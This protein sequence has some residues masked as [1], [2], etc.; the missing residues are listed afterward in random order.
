MAISP[1]GAFFIF[2]SI[3]LGAALSKILRLILTLEERICFSI[4]VGHATSATIL[5]LISY[6]HGGLDFLTIGTGIVVI[7]VAIV[8]MLMR[9]RPSIK[10]VVTFEAERLFTI[11]FGLIAFTSLNLQCVLREKSGSLY[12]SSYVTGDYCFHISVI[13]SFVYRNNFPP[14]Y[15]VMLDASMAYPPLVD[16]LSSILMETG[17]DLRSSIIIPNVLFQVSLLCWIASLAIRITGRKNVGLL[18]ALL[19]F[20]SSNL[21]VLYAFTDIAKYGFVNWMLNLPTDYS[22]SGISP[23]PGIR[24]GNPVVVMLMPQRASSLGMGISI[25]AYALIFHAIRSGESFREIFLSGFLTGL[26]PSIHPHSF[27]TV[28]IIF[29][30]ESVLFKKNLKF[31][32]FFLTPMVILAFPQLLYIRTQV[33]AGF[34]GSSIGWLEENTVKIMS[35]NW[36]TPVGVLISALRSISILAFFWFM[37]IGLILIPFA[38]GFFK[39]S[40]FVRSFSLPYL[41]VFLL[42]NFVRFQPW[43]WDNY[44]IFLHCY[45]LILTITSFGIL[46]FLKIL[47]E[48]LRKASNT[49]MQRLKVMLG[50]T[51]LAI[52]LFF[53]TASGF[54]SHA[55]VFQEDLL[56]WPKADVEFAEWVRDNTPP[57]SIFLT[58]THFLNPIP[59]LAGRQIVLG[60][61]GWLWSHGIRW[62]RIQKVKTDVIEMFRGN[63]TLI[64]QY[65]IH[66]I[67]ITDYEKL[68]AED[69]GFIIN[70]RFFNESG[71]FEKV[72]DKTL[73][74]RRYLVFKIL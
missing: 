74:G 44:K 36:D 26:L 61:E 31:F 73:E 42:G 21:G 40:R 8:L 53:S 68:F 29:F 58:G 45:I 35:L 46:E 5:Y 13:N 69:N 67:V 33:V 4:L 27:L 50:Y 9:E 7:M 22:G 37:N 25:I 70:I 54:L 72:Y 71:K 59:T 39:T 34:V 11:L 24:F 56:M 63:Y 3:S 2:L 38:F 49:H 1:L 20:F 30:L 12:G 10:G 43:D 6:L 15:P 41:L 64:K 52:V 19:F 55:K 51:F 60:Y 57:E 47:R 62:E 65:D 48:G 23:L 17:F 14:Q 32:T 18:S 16:F 28:S 66:F